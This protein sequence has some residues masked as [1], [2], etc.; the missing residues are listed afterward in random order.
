MSFQPWGGLAR[1]SSGT[2]RTPKH[3]NAK[4]EALSVW[5]LPRECHRRWACFAIVV[6]L[7]GLFTSPGTLENK[8]ASHLLLAWPVISLLTTHPSLGVRPPSRPPW[9]PSDF[10]PCLSSPLWSFFLKLSSREIWGVVFTLTRSVH[11]SRQPR[12]PLS[13]DLLV[14]HRLSVL[15]MTPSAAS[16]GRC[17]LRLRPERV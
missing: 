11:T 17:L 7:W 13:A 3:C 6:S 5:P 16:F 2:F 12:A 4:G 8:S 1:L 10:S 14:Q 9:L 15:G